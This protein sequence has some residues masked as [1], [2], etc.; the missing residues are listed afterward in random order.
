MTTTFISHGQHEASV[1]YTDAVTQATVQRVFMCSR[2]GGYVQEI[3]D[4]GRTQQVCE[5]LGR[6]GN[7]LLCSAQE[8]LVDVLR[9]EFRKMRR[10]ERAELAR[11]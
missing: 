8:S 10:R 3:Y 11:F 4:A 7:T 2:N 5:A 9:R 1:T 6:T